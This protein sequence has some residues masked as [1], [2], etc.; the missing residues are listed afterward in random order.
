M[1]RYKLT[2]WFSPEQKPTR[3][4]VY[5]CRDADGELLFRQWTGSV[6]CWGNYAKVEW[7]ERKIPSQVEE[8]S[9]KLPWRGL[10]SE[11]GQ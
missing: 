8:A 6:W 3:V 4:G 9:D 1:S 7:A 5:Q 11:S 2:E 10:I